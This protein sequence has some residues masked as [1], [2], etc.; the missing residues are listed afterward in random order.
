LVEDYEM[1]IVDAACDTPSTHLQRQERLLRVCTVHALQVELGANSA[2]DTDSWGEVAEETA[3]S[4]VPCQI[5]QVGFFIEQA[6]ALASEGRKRFASNE[7]SAVK[8]K[9]KRKPKKK[10]TG[11]KKRTHGE[12]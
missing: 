7:P 9:K 12:L 11:K 4:V 1:D 5:D 3:E 6:K 2:S 8:T 10:G